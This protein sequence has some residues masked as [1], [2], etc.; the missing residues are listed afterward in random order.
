[1]Y[2]NTQNF[3]QLKS[4]RVKS[5]CCQTEIHSIL[6]ALTTHRFMYMT[7]KY[8]DKMWSEFDLENKREENE[9]GNEIYE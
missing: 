1:M 7:K 8:D 3:T 6:Y 5:A 4:K 2:L 9:K